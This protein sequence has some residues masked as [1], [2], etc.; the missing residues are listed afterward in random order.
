MEYKQDLS[1]T[2][3]FPIV[4]PEGNVVGK[5]TRKECHSGT[6]LLHPVVHL[7]VF[8]KVGELFLQRRALTKY[9]QPGKWDTAVGGHR[10]YGETVE[11]ALQREAREEIG[12]MEFTA[13]KLFHYVYDS[14]VERELVDTF[15]TITDQETFNCD[16]EEVIEGRFWTIKQIIEAMG[17]GVLTPNFE[18][19]FKL[20]MPHLEDIFPHLSGKNK[21]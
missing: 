12:I 10:D 18:D 2:E 20:I 17:E 1:E 13:H 16:P 3:I 6:R 11:Q 15:Y 5:A 19:E 9:I 7:H 8:N 14:D 4:D 21:E